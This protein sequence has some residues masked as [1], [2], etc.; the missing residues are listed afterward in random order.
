MRSQ[1]NEKKR[2]S[3]IQMIHIGKAKL[4]MSDDAYRAFLSSVC[5]RDSC[6][7]MTIRQLE[8]VLKV[9][10]DNGF[11]QTPNRVKPE[12]KGRATLEQLEYIKG[13]WA[14]CARNKGDSA[15]AAFVKRI[16]HVDSLR[17]LTVDL[18]KKV[19]L[20]LREMMT[21]AGHDP[22]TSEKLPQGA[23]T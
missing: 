9:M 2:N 22:D 20:A 10:R 17:F 15:L 4:G 8:R 7:K 6:Q 23:M 11:E 13:M 18:A 14:V 1:T 21:K 5:G 16:A 12:E 3:L 19:I